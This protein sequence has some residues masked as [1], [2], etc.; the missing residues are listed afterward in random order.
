MVIPT[1][2]DFLGFDQSPIKEIIT[3]GFFLSYAFLLGMCCTLWV[4]EKLCY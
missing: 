1:K 3:G 4:I 2:S